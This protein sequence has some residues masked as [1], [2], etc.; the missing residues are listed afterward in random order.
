M[1]QFRLVLLH[2]ISANNPAAIT[3]TVLNNWELFYPRPMNT[4]PPVVLQVRNI[5]SSAAITI[6]PASWT[7]PTANLT[8]KENL[9]I[10]TTL[11]MC[12]LTCGCSWM[13]TNTAIPTTQA[14]RA[15]IPCRLPSRLQISPVFRAR[16]M[17]TG[18]WL[19]YCTCGRCGW[20]P[21]LNTPST[22]PWCA[23]NC[24]SH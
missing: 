20:H 19:Q 14:T 13:R 5:G 3:A 22:K 4:V 8:G 23:L 17:P 9:R 24:R 15:A 16:L 6:L 10:S 11:P 12:L 7:N 21:A 2:R 1:Y 18:I